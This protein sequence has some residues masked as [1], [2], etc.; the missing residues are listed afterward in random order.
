MLFRTPSPTLS[1]SQATRHGI[2]MGG[3]GGGEGWRCSLGSVHLCFLYGVG[4]ANHELT[5][6]KSCACNQ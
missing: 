1:P 4:K 5:Q 6:A 3:L 2:L